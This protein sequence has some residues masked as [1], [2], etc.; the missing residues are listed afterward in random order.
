MSLLLLFN[1]ASGGG[2]GSPITFTSYGPYDNIPAAGADITSPSISYTAGQPIIVESGSSDTLTISD[3]NGL[4]WNKIDASLPFV[5][6]A[7]EYQYVW[8]AIPS[9]SG[10]T[11]ITVTRASSGSYYGFAVCVYTGGAGT[12]IFKSTGNLAGYTASAVPFSNTITPTTSGS[13][14]WTFYHTN[15]GVADPTM[16]SGSAV[17]TSLVI[18]GNRTSSRLGKTTEPLTSSAAVT[19]SGVT[20]T[21][22]QYP[23]WINYEVPSSGSGGGGTAYTLTAQGGSYSLSGQSVS[24]LRSKRIIS[25][26]GSYAITGQFATVLRSKSLTASGGSYTTVGQNINLNRNRFL[27]A[28]GGSYSVGGQS[29]NLYRNRSLSAS[30]GTYTV[31]G[32][33]ANLYRSKLLI[34]SGGS[35]AM[36]G[37]P[38]GITYSA[39]SAAYTLIAQGGVYV[40]TGQDVVLKRSKNLIASGGSYSL[41]GQQ[42]TLKKS[43]ILIA[44][45]GQYSAIGQQ[46]ILLRGKRLTASGGEYT[47]SGGTIT[48]T[49]G[50]PYPPPS[51]VLEGVVYGPG[52]ILVG[53]LKAV[54]F[55]I[56]LDIT[57]GNLVKPIND[58]LVMTL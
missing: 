2:G 46:A 20:D 50:T 9:S 54:S 17:Y 11:A 38:A 7:G 35:Y 28:S 5:S 25:A 55:G 37:Q 58:K 24:V 8:Y 4:T 47:Y 48:L 41:T 15:G 12:P 36:V 6:A 45:G 53:T 34:A 40:V 18:A 22:F 14:V 30:G 49:H 26:G 1:Q 43:K 29:V 52:G 10:T 56:K 42:A 16:D 51:S 27:T 33:L 23:Q 32:Q 3:S 44:S 13:A 31:T 57:T 19:I 39:G 21:A